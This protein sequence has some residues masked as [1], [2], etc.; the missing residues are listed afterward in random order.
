MADSPIALPAGHASLATKFSRSVQ[1]NAPETARLERVAEILRLARDLSI[2]EFH[3]AHGVRRRAVIAEHEF[4]DPELPIS[5]I[6]WTA[7][8]FSFG[9]TVLLS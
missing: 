1:S 5:M 6:R 9:C 7:K 3:D 8:R 2:V 4:A